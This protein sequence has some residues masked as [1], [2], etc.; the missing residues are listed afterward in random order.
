MYGPSKGYNGA[1]KGPIWPPK[2][3][4]TMPITNI[5]SHLSTADLFL[6]H[7]VQVDAETG[8]DFILQGGQTMAD[9]AAL[10]LAAFNAITAVEG[11]ANARQLASYD[12]LV[13]RT[14]INAIIGEFNRTVRYRFRQAHYPKALRH[15][16]P[17]AGGLGV[18]LGAI[19]DVSN[20]WT[21]INA[22]TPPVSG[23][24]PPFLL[25]TLTLAQFNTKGTALHAA[26]SA[27]KGKELDLSSA[28]EARNDTLPPLRAIM[29]LYRQAVL[30]TFPPGH[31]LVDS[32]PAVSPPP[33]STPA[34]VNMGAAWNPAT[35]KA[36]IVWT[37][38]SDPNLLQYQIRACDPPKYKGSDEEV[39][40]TIPPGTNAAE[41]DFGLLVPGSSKIFAVY[42]MTTTGNEK[43]S[44]VV[45][46]TRP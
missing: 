10:R 5:P 21:L 16:P 6:A 23:F 27:L 14:E 29:V 11:P 41:T 9:L 35:G 30:A 13:K 46:V 38:S 17:K 33:G 3:D 4:N 44:N 28:R 24:T 12:L 39:V 26:F 31:Y 7:W 34:A 2:K 19:A 40:A 37:T 22:N 8:A 18:M 32:C 43:R 42:V 20:L 15:A 36:D 45:K 25:G 1:S